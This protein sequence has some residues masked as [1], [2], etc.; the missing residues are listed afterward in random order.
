MATTD[1]MAPTV[2]VL[3]GH[4]GA[5]K[6][7]LATL[8]AHTLGATYLSPFTGAVGGDLLVAA[9]NGRHEQASALAHAAVDRCVANSPTDIVVLDRHWMTVCTL[10]PEPWWSAW[11]PPPP[12]TLCWSDLATT[13]QRLGLRDETR[14]PDHWH[15]H[16]L[17][18]YRALA[19]RWRCPVLR[20][21]TMEIPESLDHLERWGRRQIRLCEASGDDRGG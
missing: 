15:R 9:L 21:D 1:D 14:E 20:T 7:T 8:L 12:T 3:D 2:L 17:R 5:G 18:L 13:Q 16:Y 6:T 10:L 4:D 19:Q 11:T